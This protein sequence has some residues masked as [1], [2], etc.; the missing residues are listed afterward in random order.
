MKDYGCQGGQPHDLFPLGENK[1]EKAE[2]CK[3]CR[4]E[5][6]YPKDST[7]RVDNEK[8]FKDHIRNFVQP[9]GDNQD[10][11]RALYGDPNRKR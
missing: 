6:K 7:G 10:L 11:Y 3:I 1:K 9:Y 8:Y 4:K 5:F 2:E